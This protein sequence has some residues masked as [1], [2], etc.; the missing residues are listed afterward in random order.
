MVSY[1]SKTM[2]ID[3][4]SFSKV[5]DSVH[6][7][8]HLNTILNFSLSGTKVT[9]ENGYLKGSIQA[10]SLSLNGSYTYKQE[11]NSPQCQYDEI[12][13]F[14]NN[15]TDSTALTFQMTNQGFLG[16][17]V[18]SP[19]LSTINL[20]PNPASDFVHIQIP[21]KNIKE[22]TVTDLLGRTLKRFKIQSDNPT[23]DITSLAPG[24]YY[25]R[26]GNSVQKLIVKRE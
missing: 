17:A 24:I 15:F 6:V 23:C 4:L 5:F 13:T 1:N 8:N 10:N 22:I 9:D 12:W 3:S 14:L 18:S 21:N 2:T 20:Y 26:T 11:W 25:F 7:V 16:M 19:I